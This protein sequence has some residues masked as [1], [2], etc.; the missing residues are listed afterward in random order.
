MSNLIWELPI[1]GNPEDEGFQLGLGF[2]SLFIFEDDKIV[3]SYMISP[4]ELQIMWSEGNFFL[5]LDGTP[6]GSHY[7]LIA[8]NTHGQIWIKDDGEINV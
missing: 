4:S 7:S 2:C 6:H 8:L 1:K 3:E 5:F